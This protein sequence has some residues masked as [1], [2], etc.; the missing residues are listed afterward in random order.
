MGRRF[1][2]TLLGYLAFIVVHMPSPLADRA[3]SWL[4]SAKIRHLTHHRFENCNYGVT[5]VFR[6]S[7][8]ALMQESSANA[9]VSG[10]G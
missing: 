5:T 6:T 7:C 10:A 9:Y 4:Y 8:F 3:K 2:R 1:R